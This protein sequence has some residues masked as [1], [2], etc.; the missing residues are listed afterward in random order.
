MPQLPTSSFGSSYSYSGS[1]R[2]YR[3]NNYR[4]SKDED[5]FA[6]YFV[7]MYINDSVL[8]LKRKVSSYYNSSEADFFINTFL[9]SDGPHP[10]FLDSLLTGDW[11]NFITNEVMSYVNS[12]LNVRGDCHNPAA[13]PMLLNN[14]FILTQ[15]GM[16]LYPPGF[17][18]NNYQLIIFIPWEKLKPY[19]RKD[20]ASKIG[21]K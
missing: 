12:N 20:A 14:R 11:K 5:K 15:K 16:F 6:K 21:L 8:S 3:Q 13:I 7:L 18:E 9:Y 4:W 17:S 10:V 2:T 1:S 19:L